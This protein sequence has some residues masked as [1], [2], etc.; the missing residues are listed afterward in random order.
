MDSICF[1]VSSTT[2]TIIIRDVPPKDTLTPNTPAQKI[3]IT[4]TIIKPTAPIKIILFKIQIWIDAIILANDI[5][6]NPK[7]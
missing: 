4:A 1:K 7:N 5:W 3:G 2:P 6:I